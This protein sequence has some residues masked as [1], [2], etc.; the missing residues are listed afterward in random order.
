MAAPP[1]CGHPGL[2]R[3]MASALISCASERPT[4]HAF[5]QPCGTAVV[6]E[7]IAEMIADVQV[8]AT[9]PDRSKLVTVHHPIP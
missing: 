2:V 1:W 8:E 3:P 4:V 6:M 5:D 7:G 9:F